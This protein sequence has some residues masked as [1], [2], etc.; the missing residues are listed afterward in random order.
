MLSRSIVGGPVVW[1][2][3][4]DAARAGIADNDWVEIYNSNGAIVARAVVSQRM[5]EGTTFMY[6]A[7]E[8]S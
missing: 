1:I 3:E 2:A 4:P 6:H 5:R 8:R 7:Q